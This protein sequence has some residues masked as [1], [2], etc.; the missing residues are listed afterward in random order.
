MKCALKK[1][2]LSFPKQAKTAVRKTEL[3]VST[4]RRKGKEKMV[5]VVGNQRG[6][7]F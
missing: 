2:K 4:A 3:H 5:F 7:P 1:K 6:G